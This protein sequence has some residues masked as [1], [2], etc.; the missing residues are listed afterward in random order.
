MT[1][2]PSTKSESAKGFWMLRLEAGLLPASG[3]MELT[4]LRVSPAWLGW[5]KIFLKAKSLVG[6]MPEPISK[7]GYS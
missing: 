1:S 7:V 6:S 4:R 2:L 3:K 5:P